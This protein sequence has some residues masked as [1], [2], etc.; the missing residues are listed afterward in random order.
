VRKDV[1]IE[2]FDVVEDFPKPGV[3]FYDIQGLTR[4][5][6]N[7]ELAIKNL[8]LQVELSKTRPNVIVAADARG[9]LV[10]GALSMLLQCRLILAR[11][12]GKLPG[13]TLSAQYSTEYGCSSISIRTRQLIPTD[14]VLIVDDVLAT[15]GT[16]L[17]IDSLVKTAKAETVLVATLLRLYG[18]QTEEYNLP[19]VSWASTIGK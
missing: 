2:Y 6:Y 12:P 9:F 11:K 8:A 15:G 16:V 18:L 13:D 19:T 4:N 1:R 17:A 7:W 10:A 5:P 3:T 14:R